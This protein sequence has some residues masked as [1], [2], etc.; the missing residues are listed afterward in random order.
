VPRRLLPYLLLALLALVFFGEL[1]LHPTRL[2]YSDNSDLLALHLPSKWFLVRSFQETGELPLWCPYSFAGMPFIHDPQVTAFYPPHW[3]LLLL[4]PERLGAALSWLVVL[5]VVAAGWCAYAYARWRGLEPLPAFIAAT[6]YMFAGKWLLHVLAAGHY[7]MVPIAWLP[8]VL[9]ALEGAICTGSRLRAVA[10]GA[11]FALIVLGAYPYMTLYAGAFIALWTLTPA[12]ER[13][14][15]FGSPRITSTRSAL[16]RWL[17]YGMLTAAVAVALSAVE[18]L[19]ALEAARLATRSGYSQSVGFVLYGGLQTLLGLTG[20]ALADNPPSQLWE[21][22]GAWGVLWLVALAWA[23]VTGDRRVRFQVVICL[24]LI[25]FSVGGGAAVT[26]LPGF[27]IFRYPSRML[28]IAAFPVAYLAGVATQ[29]LLSTPDLTG[30]RLRRCRT[31]LLVIAAAAVGLTALS[32][33]FLL[34]TGSSPRWPVYWLFAAAALMAAYGLVGRLG[35]E[36]ARSAASTVLGFAPGGPR[37]Y[38]V[39]WVVL[40]VADLWFIALP[41]V[42]VRSQN[43][44]YPESESVRWLADRADEHG[45]VLDR[46]PLKRPGET[47]L[48]A[49]APMAQIAGIEPLR[50]FNPIDVRHYKEYL[51]FVG[52]ADAPL[53][54]LVNPVAFPTLGNFPVKNRQLLD[55]LGTRYL[56]QPAEMPVE[57]D[58]WERMIDDADPAAF[59]F[60][61][62]GVRRLPPFTVWRNETAFPRAFVVGRAE[63]LPARD[64]VLAAL[65]SADLRRTVFL[66]DWNGPA[67]EPAVDLRPAQVIEYQPNRVVVRTEAGPAGYLVLADVWYPGWRCTVDGREA[68]LYRADYLF[69]GVALPEGEHTV[70]FTFEPVSY[71]VGRIVSAAALAGVLGL[72]LFGAVRKRKPLAA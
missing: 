16:A 6:G 61:A 15:F 50:G 32:G 17:G 62:G 49:G 40:L 14:G 71:R 57:G 4:Q 11:V 47:P 26:W 1:V 24:L 66:E 9:L 43:E 70:A 8:L 46:D 53:N 5:H 10:A 51:Q 22:R 59:D 60:L 48:G 58:G 72:L 30:D 35:G 54:P 36:P 7:N 28:M 65:R 21:D 41:A 33:L 20:P 25:L 67:A 42:A 27:G 12:L 55:L 19:P 39:F 18:L 29:A 23:Y 68:T 63:R 52:D 45:R 56:L 64:R 31:A 69:R 44:V 13:A 37:L 3:P 38:A 2:L 34:V